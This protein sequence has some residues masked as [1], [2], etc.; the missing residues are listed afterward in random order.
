[1]L[2]RLYGHDNR[3]FLD[4]LRDLDFA[5]AP[6]SCSNYPYTALVVSAMLNF[7]YVRNVIG[8]QGAM[9]EVLE[10]V[11]EPRLFRILVER[12]Y[13]IFT[14]TSS[15]SLL[16][17]ELSEHNVARR[18]GWSLSVSPFSRELLAMTPF[19]VDRVANWIWHDP[20][21]AVSPEVAEIQADLE[22]LATIAQIPEPTFVFMHLMSPHEPFLF[23]R[24]GSARAE[25]I[26]VPKNRDWNTADLASFRENYAEEVAGLNQRLLPS[27]EA[28]LEASPDPPVILLLGDHG[29]RPHGYATHWTRV[30]DFVFGD[31]D[32][33]PMSIVPENGFLDEWM[34]ILHAAHLP[35]QADRFYADISPVN[36][37]RLILSAYLDL[38][39]P[40]LPDRSFFPRSPNPS[41]TP[42][43]FRDITSDLHR[44]PTGRNPDA[45][46]P[47]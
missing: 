10:S 13:R 12:G 45:A 47:A 23:H 11:A 29:P 36:A 14:L 25:R 40:P 24:D 7:D 41:S 34:G 18:R 26:H 27:I 28:L 8:E 5:I 9:R 19:D 6:E 1:V 3:P 39:T 43:E 46:N 21:H 42:F 17:H 37:V 20:E 22:A 15:R 16:H 38:D 31:T 30:G 33:L 4:G 32:A 44:E 35:G 2:Q